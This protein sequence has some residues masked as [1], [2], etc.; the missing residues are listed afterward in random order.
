MGVPAVASLVAVVAASIIVSGCAATCGEFDSCSPR[1]GPRGA[2]RVEAALARVP[3]GSE[4][5]WLG[6]QLF[7]RENTGLDAAGGT[8]VVSQAVHYDSAAGRKCQMTLATTYLGLHLKN[9]VITGSA[10]FCDD[11]DVARRLEDAGVAAITL[12]SLP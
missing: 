9:P 7:T 3:V 4:I 6:E 2:E 11:L 12:R 5:F 8:M 1:S 10:P